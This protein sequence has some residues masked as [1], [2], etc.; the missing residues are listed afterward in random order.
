MIFGLDYSRQV[1][2]STLS[3]TFRWAAAF[4][5]KVKF[6]W[7]KKGSAPHMS[8]KSARPIFVKILVWGDSHRK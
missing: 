8:N 5:S 2:V 1:Q 6:D 7:E 3:E 4:L